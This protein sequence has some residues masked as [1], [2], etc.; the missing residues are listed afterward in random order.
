M[1]AQAG[2]N[3]HRADVIAA[4]RKGG[5]TLAGLA[6]AS[7]LSRQSFSW[8]LIKPHPRA[9]H[10]IAK[11]LGRHV[12]TIWPEWFDA[13]GQRRDALASSHRRAQRTAA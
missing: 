11:H 1:V 6:R 4:V 9:N 13:T 7:G 8:A 12:S 5:T 3:W 2:K 10:A